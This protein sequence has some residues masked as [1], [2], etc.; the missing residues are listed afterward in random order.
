MPR[1]KILEAL[2]SAADIYEA[3]YKNDDMGYGVF[4]KLYTLHWRA[5]KLAAETDKEG[6]WTVR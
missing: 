1:H 3:V 4:W 5:A 6:H 2:T